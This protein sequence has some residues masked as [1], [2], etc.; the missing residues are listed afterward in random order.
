MS[1]TSSWIAFFTAIGVGTVIAAVLS[2]WSVISNHRQNW[3]NAL[4]DDLAAYLKEID[5]YHYRVSKLNAVSGQEAALA[6]ID[7]VQETKDAALLVY[8]RILLRLNMTEDQHVKLGEALKALL[9]NEGDFA[10]VEDVDEVIALSRRVL[11]REWAVTK[12]GIL[13]PIVLSLKTPLKEM[14]DKSA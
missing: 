14:W 5:S 7:K 10:G 1:A 11:K 12:Y 8:R 13:T 2:R 9:C 3:I 4:R 6:A